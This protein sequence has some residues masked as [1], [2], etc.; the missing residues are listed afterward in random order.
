M[1]SPAEPPFIVGLGGA[2]R[3]GSSS[4]NAVRAAL[5]HAEA[6]GAR[7][8]LFD[9]PSLERLPHFAPER[10]DRSAEQAEFVDA[11]RAADGL[12]VGAPA[13]HG[14]MSGLVK[15]AL[16]VLEDLRD[17]ARPYLHGRAVG[18]V[19]T[20]AG[21]QAGGVT[22][23]ALRDVVHAL[24]G[25]PTPAGAAFNTGGGPLF[26]ADGRAVDPRTDEM[27]ALVARQV[28]GFARMARGEGGRALE[29]R[30]DQ[31]GTAP[32]SGG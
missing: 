15:N 24:R 16:D 20:S 14:G 26:G 13:Y 22:L 1:P 6:L 17:D 30:G 11:V 28:V 23:S 3:A 31:S 21:W 25:W 10:A 7:V 2:T 27:L 12:M 5:A 9:G 19:V 8:R 18:L 29:G 32:R 4:E